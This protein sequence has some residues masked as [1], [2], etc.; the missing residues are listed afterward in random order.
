MTIADKLDE[1]RALIEKGWTQRTYLSGPSGK[2]CF[3][4][5]GAIGVAVT[6][7]ALPMFG[8]CE[9]PVAPV[10]TAFGLAIGADNPGKVADW[11]D[12]P[13]RIQAEVIDAFKRAAELARAG[14]A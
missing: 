14:A 2:E 8:W 1:A 4:S 13:E 7:K 12:A 5:L 11:N 10:V 9:G 6:G 3:C